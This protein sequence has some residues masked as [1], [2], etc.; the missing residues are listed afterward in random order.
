MNAR[1]RAFAEHYATTGNAA[2]AARRAGYS[3]KTARAIGQKLLTKADIQEYIHE[4]QSKASRERIAGAEEVAS[5][6][7]VMLRDCS[8]AAG[9]R[10]RAANTL[11][12]AG[13]AFLPPAPPVVEMDTA[14]VHSD[15]QE[16][17]ICLPYT[18]RDAVQPNAVQ[19]PGGDIVPL[20]GHEG[21]DILIFARFELTS[22]ADFSAKEDDENEPEHRPME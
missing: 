17:R 15:D 11:L 8:L 19:L 4:L 21:D 3:P 18:P 20:A 5:T 1:Q 2:E 16:V 6:L 12:R 9:T 13:G 10:I 14:D 7:T 22:A